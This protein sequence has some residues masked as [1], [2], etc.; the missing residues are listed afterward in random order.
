MNEEEYNS[1]INQ[2]NVLDHTAL[3]VT[4]KELVSRQE[5]DLAADLRRIIEHNKI[6]KPTLHAKP[7]D[8][9]ATYYTIDLSA[10]DVEKIIDIFFDLEA[11][12]VDENGETTPTSSFYAS[13][14]DKWSLLR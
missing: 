1:L 10:E 5:S 12:H 14:V 13:L 9:S 7:Y 4:L 2:K 3:N 6:P 11:S 8:T